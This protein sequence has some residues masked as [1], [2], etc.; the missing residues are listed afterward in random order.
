MIGFFSFF[1]VALWRADGEIPETICSLRRAPLVKRSGRGGGGVGGGSIN[2]LDGQS[3]WTGNCCDEDVGRFPS[4]D[5]DVTGTPFIGPS[6]GTRTCRYT[7]AILD[8]F[9]VVLI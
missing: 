1:S 6:T 5:V 2:Q 4:H 8:G 7:A 3:N 9:D